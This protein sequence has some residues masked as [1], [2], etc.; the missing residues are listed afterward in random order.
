MNRVLCFT[1]VVAIGH[2]IQKNISLQRMLY[3]LSSN[4]RTKSDSL[5][6]LE[7]FDRV[8][9]AEGDQVCSGMHIIR[10]PGGW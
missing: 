2:R 9:E 4:H 8:Y 10:R 1:E 3:H 6:S 7:N 5:Y